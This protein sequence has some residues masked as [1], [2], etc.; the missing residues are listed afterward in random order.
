MQ[1]ALTASAALGSRNAALEGDLKDEQERVSELEAA[2]ASLEEQLASASDQAAKQKSACVW[3]VGCWRK[4]I[5]A[6]VVPC[7][8]GLC[9]MSNG[10][11]C[12]GPWDALQL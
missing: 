5:A 6:A 2:A 8:A 4:G 11:A 12:A 9:V 10:G 3:G 1:A 7:C